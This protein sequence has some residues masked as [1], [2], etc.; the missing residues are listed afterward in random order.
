MSRTSRSGRRRLGPFLAPRRTPRR[1]AR[2]G[3]EGPGRSGPGASPVLSLHDVLGRGARLPGKRMKAATATT[4]EAPSR[5]RLRISEV[6][7]YLL[8]SRLEEPL[9]FSF[10]VKRE[11]A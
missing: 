10:G 6:K 9:Q 2:R 1:G 3:G 4:E 8:A 7:A 5:I 11:R